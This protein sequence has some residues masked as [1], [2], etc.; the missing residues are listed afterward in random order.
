[1]F[2]W[3]IVE[4]QQSKVSLSILSLASSIYPVSISMPIEF[5]L[6]LIAS[7]IVVP[8]PAKGSSIVSLTKLNNFMHLRGSSLGN[9][10]G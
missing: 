4:T 5:R 9:G 1:M 3:D 8:L 6:L 2:T 7:S 10:A